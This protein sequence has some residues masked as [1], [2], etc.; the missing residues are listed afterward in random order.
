M[1]RA[2]LPADLADFK[3]TYLEK[4][5]MPVLALGGEHCFE[6]RVLETF[7]QVAKR[8]EGGVVQGATHY[9]PLERSRATAEPILSFLAT[10]SPP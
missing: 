7:Q 5:G 10:S 1:S 4:L 2:A 6:R 3:E 8:V 9:T